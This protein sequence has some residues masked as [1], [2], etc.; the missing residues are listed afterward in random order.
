MFNKP[1]ASRLFNMFL[2][3]HL[4]NVIF[5]LYRLHITM[6]S[7]CLYHM[8]VDGVYKPLIPVGF[9]LFL[10]AVQLGLSDID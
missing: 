10:A 7:L 4:I 3:V 6:T 2:L 9:I 5:L 1:Q 8:P